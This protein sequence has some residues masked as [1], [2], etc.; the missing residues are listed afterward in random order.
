MMKLAV[1]AV[2]C[3]FLLIGAMAMPQEHF[4]RRGRRIGT[5]RSLDDDDHSGTHRGSERRPET[6][7]LLRGLSDQ[8]QC[9][10]AV[11]YVYRWYNS[12][13]GD[14]QYCFDS[15]NSGSS[16]YTYQEMGFETLKYQQDSTVPFYELYNS[17]EG[18]FYT[19]NSQEVEKAQR[20]GWQLQ[21]NIGF[22]FTIE[23]TGSFAIHQYYSSQYNSHFY[24][25]NPE[26]ENLNG[27][28]DQGVI[29][30]TFD[31]SSNC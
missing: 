12:N 3:S 29:G 31:T 1:I 16:G 21:G 30:Y 2:I 23:V 27:W 6:R 20:L 22:V 14:Y 4:S 11:N 18:Y 10:Y 8:T 17:N 28:T 25:I 13:T 26:S 19:T 15:Q 24:T 9:G 7:S 5:R